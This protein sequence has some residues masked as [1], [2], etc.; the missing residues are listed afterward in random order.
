[1]QRVHGPGG[2]EDRP[3]SRDWFTRDPVLNALALSP[4]RAIFSAAVGYVIWGAVLHRSALD[5]FLQ[6]RVWKLP[7]RLSY[8][9]YLLHI[10][11]YGWLKPV[12][13]L[14][15]ASAPYGVGVTY[16]WLLAVRIVAVG[17]VAAV[18][19]V[20]VEYPFMQF[21]SSLKAPPKKPAAANGAV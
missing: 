11:V 19:H 2:S 18:L 5:G 21:A 3:A 20:L 4:G 7:A 1:M 13:A 14:V 10:M 8:G 17:A 9:M 12:D 6:A 15:E 16:C